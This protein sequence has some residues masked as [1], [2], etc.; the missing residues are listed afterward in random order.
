MEEDGLLVKRA[1][2][3]S[4]MTCIRGRSG[5]V[6]ESPPKQERR[7]KV[8]APKIINGR[9]LLLFKKSGDKRR[10]QH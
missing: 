3:N 7:R 8:K 2:L 10:E 6:I 1:S 4:Q 5:Q 9:K